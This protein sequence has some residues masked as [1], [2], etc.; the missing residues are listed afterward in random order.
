MGKGSGSGAL[1]VFAIAG[2][3][4]GCSSGADNTAPQAPAASAPSA[5]GAT[6]TTSA[7]GSTLFAQNCAGCHGQNGA[8]GKAPV[9]AGKKIAESEVVATVTNGKGRRMPAFGNRLSKDQIDAIGKYV[10]AL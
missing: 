8:N 4:A 6:A 9:L 2:I 3:I 5:G 1:V 10:N 7:D